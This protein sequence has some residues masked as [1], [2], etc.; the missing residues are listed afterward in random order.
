M[1]SIRNDS[2][3][4]QGVRISSRG[5]LL[6]AV[7]CLA[8]SIFAIVR[9]PQKQHSLAARGLGSRGGWADNKSSVARLRE[10]AVL[11]YSMRRFAQVK[12]FIKPLI[13]ELELLCGYAYPTSPD[14]MYSSA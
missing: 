5:R 7:E 3:A 4:D 13:V 14:P 9:F 6:L 12:A 11:S 8:L 1:H 10:D 2:V